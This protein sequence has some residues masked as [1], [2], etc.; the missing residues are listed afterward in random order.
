[1][2]LIMK[3]II[4]FPA[5][6]LTSLIAV[7]ALTGCE[8][9]TANETTKPA[10]VKNTTDKQQ[11][12][13]SDAW[14][15]NIFSQC[16]SGHG[17]CLPDDEK[18]FTKRYMEFYQEQLQIFEYP[19]FATEAELLTAKKSYNNKW[20]NIYPLD[21]EVSTPFGQ[22]NGMMAGDT[23]EN[24]SITRTADLQ[25]NVLVEY[26]DGEVSSNNLLL[27]P[28]GDTF[29]ID[30]IDTT[31]KEKK[32]IQVRFSE[33]GIDK[34]LPVF[35]KN[36]AQATLYDDASVDSGIVATLPDE[37][38][39]VLIGL[40]AVKDKANR[41]WYKCYYPKEQLQGWTRQVSHWDFSEDARHLPLLQNL[42]L[43]NLQL[44]A[45]PLE[46]KR[47]LGKPKSETSETGP[48]E[49]S[50]YIDEDYIVTT[51]T[52][53]YDGIQLIYQD[54]MMIHAEISQPGKSFGW[55]TIGD[56]KWNKDSIMKRFKLTDED[57]YNNNEGV[58]VLAINRDILSLSIYLDA[59]DLV[60][61]I[62]W[63]YG[64]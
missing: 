14:L 50:G 11:N 58:K 47:L 35:M 44:G 5:A 62:T 1:M 30:F 26:H 16:K 10:V 52:M 23:L 20:K 51:T 63:H 24:V 22:G 29:L 48:L 6:L 18:V 27:T 53:T 45:S 21:K 17:Y 57:F 12:S 34:L 64:S 4:S 8:Q 46:A 49:T 37:G 61:T 39:F 25:Y 9:S 7:T 32:A 55:I 60:K 3:K 36:K 43:A 15:K 13:A 2:T 59:N 42:T 40:T 33:P 31:F 28:S 54:D 19:D 56:K 41:T 38:H